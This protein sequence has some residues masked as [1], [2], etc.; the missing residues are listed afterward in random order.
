MTRVRDHSTLPVGDRYIYIACKIPELWLHAPGPGRLPGSDRMPIRRGVE[1]LDRFEIVDRGEPSTAV[2]RRARR[3]PGIAMRSVRCSRSYHSLNS[4][5]IAGS[6]LAIT[7]SIPCDFVIIFSLECT[8]VTALTR[9]RQGLLVA[10]SR[11]RYR[12]C[13]STPLQNR[14]W[15]PACGSAAPGWARSHLP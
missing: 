8:P 9:A 10:T 1:N 12:D 4:R 13:S 3:N 15:R 2:K 6:I 11:G 14:R 7:N 5:S